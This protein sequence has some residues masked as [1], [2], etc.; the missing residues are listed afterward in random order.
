[1]RAFC[2][3]LLLFVLFQVT[4]FEGVIHGIKSANGVKETFDIYMKGDL[5]SLEGEDGQGKYRIIINRATE[6]I[7]ICIDNPTFAQKGYYHFTAAQ[8]QREKKFKILS[9]AKLDGQ[10]EVNGENCQGY[11]MITDKGSVVMYAS[12][13][14][15]ADLTGLSAYM[16]DPVYELIDA[17]NVKRSIRRIAVQRESG[18]YTV[19]LEE[20]AII[21]PAEKFEIPA[22]YKE[23]EIK[24]NTK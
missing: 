10:K 13:Q 24:L 3:I 20:E 4:A 22:G 12:S 1:M 5:I 7:F 21:V 19:E 23:F 15:K 16:D 17:F 2:T 18:S 9:S 8:L 11:S 14:G 6:E